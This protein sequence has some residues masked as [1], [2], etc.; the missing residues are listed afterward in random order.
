MI[1]LI[2]QPIGIGWYNNNIC[3]L[4]E[5]GYTDFA[6]Y[7]HTNKTNITEIEKI[8]FQIYRD[9]F[10][11]NMVPQMN[12]C[13]KHCDMKPGNIVLTKSNYPLII[14]F[15][16]S[17]FKINNVSFIR[18]STG[19]S[20][21]KL[22]IFKQYYNDIYMNCIFD[23]IILLYSIIYKHNIKIYNYMP[24]ED[25]FI[26]CYNNMYSIFGSIHKNPIYK[27]YIE[28]DEFIHYIYVAEIIAIG[29]IIKKYHYIINPSDF[30]LFLSMNEYDK[31]RIA[32]MSR[33]Y[34]IKYINYKM[35]Y[36]KLKNSKN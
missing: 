32:Y 24:K 27:D 35:K 13:F 30:L 25:N 8:C 34:Y 1:K 31:E 18:P 21:D 11:I 29:D 9:L 16:F 17:M 10:T 33:I 3:F 23:F 19:S 4:S 5:A 7:L 28:Q 2:P 6:Q 12:L 20:F 26:L 14:D 36:L 15:G 22:S